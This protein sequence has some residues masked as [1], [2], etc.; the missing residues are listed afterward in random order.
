M[1][2]L[3]N[4]LPDVMYSPARKGPTKTPTPCA[5]TSMPRLLDSRSAPRSSQSMVVFWQITTPTKKPN[6]VALSIA[7]VKDVTKGHASIAKATKSIEALNRRCCC[8]RTSGR[9]KK[10]PETRRPTKSPEDNADSTTAAWFSDRPMFLPMAGANMV[11]GL[12]DICAIACDNANS[13]KRKS[14][15]KETSSVRPKALT[16]PTARFNHD[17]RF[18]MRCPASLLELMPDFGP[19]IGTS[20]FSVPLRWFSQDTFAFTRPSR[21]PVCSPHTGDS[22]NLYVVREVFYQRPMEGA[23]DAA[24]VHDSANDQKSAEEAVAFKEV[25]HKRW[26]QDSADTGTYRC[27]ADVSSRSTRR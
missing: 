4:N 21:P 17:N 20:P 24:V 5:A 2:A 25:G 19:V 15:H 8:L 22:F 9:S 6:T 13:E 27:Y 11:T 18:R 14:D 7:T 23:T 16:A 10:K 12:M 1:T 26:T 3:H